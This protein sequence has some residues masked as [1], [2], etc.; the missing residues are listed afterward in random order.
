MRNRRPRASLSDTAL[1]AAAGRA[2]ESRRPDP[3]VTD[4]LAES[5][6]DAV[7]P[8]VLDPSRKAMGERVARLLGDMF[9]LRT[10]YFDDELTRFTA[11]GGRQCVLLG[12]GLDTRAY[13][14][15]LP[16]ATTVYELD[17]PP[18]LEFKDSVLLGRSERP[19]CRRIPVRADLATDWTTP[20]IR[21]GF[22]P[23]ARTAWLAEGLLLYL[24]AR[25]GDRL[26]ATLTAHSAPHSMVLVEHVNRAA[27]TAAAGRAVAEWVAALGEPW[28][29]ELDDPARWLARFGWTGRVHD[30]RELALTH[31]RPVPP[32][33]GT[34]S[35]DDRRVWCVSATPRN[36]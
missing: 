23:R 18:T 14:L 33:A 3:L 16:S 20:L 30:I 29:S 27:Q 28:R 5:F 11:S 35:G 17:L 7:A 31:R 12:A 24:T 8:P 6:L 26:L 13:R 1:L 19:V 34:E 36:P 22:D 10:R 32:F 15:R 25:Q 2:A 9:I 21:A 4:P